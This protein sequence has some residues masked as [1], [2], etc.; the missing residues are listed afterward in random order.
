M[1]WDGV[2][3]GGVGVD[4]GGMKSKTRHRHLSIVQDKKKEKKK[5]MKGKVTQSVSELVN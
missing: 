3:H 5:R 2:R 1:R 4:W